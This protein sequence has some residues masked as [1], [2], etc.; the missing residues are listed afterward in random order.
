[1]M[2]WLMRRRWMRAAQNR[3]LGLVPAA[4]REAAL[5]SHRKQNAFALRYGL[6]ILVVMFN[7]LLASVLLTLT[8]TAS[9][10]LYEAGLFNAPHGPDAEIE[11]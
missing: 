6:R 5:A 4:K 8:L 11:P 1:M 9:L 7:I 10:R 2:L 3:A